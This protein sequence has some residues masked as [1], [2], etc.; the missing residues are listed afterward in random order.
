[1]LQSCINAGCDEQEVCG[2]DIEGGES[3]G[4]EYQVEVKAL[5]EAPASSATG[6]G[7]ANEEFQTA[8]ALWLE[9]DPEEVSVS[10]RGR[11]RGRVHSS[12]DEAKITVEGRTHAGRRVCDVYTGAS[13]LIESW[14]GCFARGR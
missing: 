7:D 10:G 9:V 13:P 8:V 14:F 6:D 1:M 2:L 12:A 5:L 3:L 4:V 11:G